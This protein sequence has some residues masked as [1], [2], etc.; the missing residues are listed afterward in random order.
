MG[1]VGFPPFRIASSAFLR[2]SLCRKA[3]SAVLVAMAV[4]VLDV[5]LLEVA[6]YLR[7]V[8]VLAVC[9]L[10][11]VGSARCSHLRWQLCEQRSRERTLVR[12]MECALCHLA[13]SRSGRM[14]I[15]AQ[16]ELRQALFG[17]QDVPF[18]G[19]Y[20]T[21]DEMFAYVLSRG[22]DFVLSQMGL[23]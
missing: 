16:L 12:A 6:E 23:S 10:T 9:R 3:L 13:P 4:V 8:P 7:E 1:L 19:E 5:V 15:S 11:R 14:P 2:S 20:A 18:P 17:P 21:D 22:Q